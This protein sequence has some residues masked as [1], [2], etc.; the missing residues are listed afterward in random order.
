MVPAVAA[1]AVGGMAADLAVGRVATEA[2]APVLVVPVVVSTVVRAVV[3]AVVHAVAAGIAVAGGAV[4]IV[5]PAG[6]DRHPIRMK[7]MDTDMGMVIPAI[8]ILTAVMSGAGGGVG[9]K[10]G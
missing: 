4:G 6:M 10:T 9:G 7:G 5:V 1:P 2:A 3:H 8:T